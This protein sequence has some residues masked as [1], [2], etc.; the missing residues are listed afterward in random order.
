MAVTLKSARQGE[1]RTRFLCLA[2][3]AAGLVPAQDSPPAPRT[4]SQ[5]GINSDSEDIDAQGQDSPDPAN[6]GPSVFNRENGL[7]AQRGGKLID[8]RLYGEITGVY[9]S[10]LAAAAPMNGPLPRFPAMGSNRAP[11][12]SARDA[13]GTRSSAWSIMVSFASMRKDRF[14]T[15]RT[16]FWIWLTGSS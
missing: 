13:G 6:T 16:S 11:A 10:G 1:F 2:L 8:L 5:P 9:D 14:S 7:L 4:Q 3:L 12:R 15:G